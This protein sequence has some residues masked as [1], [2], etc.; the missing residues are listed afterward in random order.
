MAPLFLAAEILQ[1]AELHLAVLGRL[2][3]TFKE[4]TMEWLFQWPKTQESDYWP[5]TKIMSNLATHLTKL[6]SVIVSTLRRPASL[7][8]KSCCAPHSQTPDPPLLPNLQLALL[9]L[10]TQILSSK[11]RTFSQNWD[12]SFQNSENLAQ[13]SVFRNL[14]A[15]QFAGND[16]K[17]KADLQAK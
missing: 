3:Q 15:P 16:R 1:L 5:V 7:C 12:F 9:E 6:E 13:N 2:S 10:K 17:R 4:W 8:D 11:L 14:K